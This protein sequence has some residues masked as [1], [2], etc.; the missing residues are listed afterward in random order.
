MRLKRLANVKADF[1]GSVRRVKS[2]M[3]RTVLEA[4]ALTH[5]RN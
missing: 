1:L 3:V 4:N 2:E 5:M